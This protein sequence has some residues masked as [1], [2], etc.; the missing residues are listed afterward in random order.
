MQSTESAEFVR[1]DV[2]EELTV[3]HGRYRNQ[4]FAP[5]FHETYSLGV[6][7][8]GSG[9]M[10]VRGR[11]VTFTT[12]DVVL[13]EPGEVHTGEAA[14]RNGWGYYMFYPGRELMSRLAHGLGVDGEVYFAESRSESPALARALATAGRIACTEPDLALR[15][16]SVLDMLGALIQHAHAGPRP[17]RVAPV[18]NLTDQ[19]QA[20]RAHI[21]QHCLR[22]IRIEE[23][24][25]VGAL[26]AYR[27]IRA[28]SAQFGISPYA[29]LLQHRVR[30]AQEHLADGVPV[31][32]V[33]LDTGFSD[34]SHFTRTFRR[35]VGVTPGKFARRRRKC[36]A[37]R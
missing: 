2:G 1:L 16:S 11:D 33:A 15:E 14:E 27:L 36:P 9:R 35:I 24:A 18:S 32:R 28:F 10:R 23:L 17:L 29:Y 25:Q 5:H 12:G 19:L 26:N 8:E 3:L 31:G 4:R 13:L 37:V 22:S 30:V 6:V 7:V 34:Q 20:V 21:E